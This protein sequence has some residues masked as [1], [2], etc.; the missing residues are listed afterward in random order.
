MKV[1]LVPGGVQRIDTDDLI[2]GHRKNPS[3]VAAVSA[4]HRDVD[5]SRGAQS[6]NLGPRCVAWAIGDIDVRRHRAGTTEFRTAVYAP[7]AT[8]HRPNQPP[9]TN[10]SDG[11]DPKA[12][13]QSALRRVRPLLASSVPRSPGKTGTRDKASSADPEVPEL[14]TSTAGAATATA[15]DDIAKALATAAAERM[16]ATRLMSVARFWLTP[17]RP[18]VTLRAQI[19]LASP[20]FGCHSCSTPPRRWE[21]AR[22]VRSSN[23]A[24]NS[25]GRETSVFN[26]P[27]PPLTVGGT[28]SSDVGAAVVVSH[29]SQTRRPQ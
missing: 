4:V 10:S 29:S 12:Q 7:S 19:T 8:S 25:V 26:E 1:T 28:V 20:L 5:Q 3:I 13:D 27:G 18:E 22:F 24:H 15:S 14:P 11:I 6:T 17:S 9:R 21:S 16:V 23:D 2:T